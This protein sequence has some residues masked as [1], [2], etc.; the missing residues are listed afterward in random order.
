MRN[1]VTGMLIA[2]AI[3]TGA[4]SSKPAASC[5]NI[6]AHIKEIM[7]SSDDMKKAPPDQQK[8][9][10]SMVD[11]LATEVAKECKDKNWTA[12]QLDCIMAAKKMDDMEKCDVK[13]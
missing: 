7:M 11:S 2:A 12:K 8:A 1:F 13:K 9:A 6:G 3:A 5:E 4:C 10:Q